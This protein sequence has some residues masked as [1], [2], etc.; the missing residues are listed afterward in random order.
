MAGLPEVAAGQGSGLSWMGP[1][2]SFDP[3]QYAQMALARKDE[4]DALEDKKSKE[5]FKLLDYKPGKQLNID[6]T[7]N[8]F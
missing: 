5:A 3:I 1:G 7:T 4:K 8:T 2:S 6:L